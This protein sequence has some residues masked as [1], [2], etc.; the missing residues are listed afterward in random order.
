MKKIIFFLLIICQSILSF[1]QES[2][3][4]SEETIWQYSKDE[5]IDGLTISDLIQEEEFS[6]AIYVPAQAYVGNEIKTVRL[7]FN[8]SAK[9]VKIKIWE[10]LTKDPIYEEEIGDINIT[11]SKWQ[12]FTLKTPFEITEEKPLYIG[13]SL[14]IEP[15]KKPIGIHKDISPRPYSFFFR[16]K[17]YEWSDLSS[18]FAPVCIQAYIYGKL[19]QK[20][21]V[22]VGGETS[23]VS[24]PGQSATVNLNLI[25]CGTSAANV[26]DIEYTINGKTNKL[27]SQNVIARS[28]DQIIFPLE[29]QIPEELGYYKLTVKVSKVDGRN[30][31]FTGKDHEISVAVLEN[32]TKRVVVCEELTG[33]GCAYCPKGIEGLRIMYEKYPDTFLGIAVHEFNGG[34]KMAVADGS[35][36]EINTKMTNAPTCM[37][38][39][40][41]DLIGDPYSKIEEMYLQEAG[42]YPNMKVDMYVKPTDD[43]KK[44]EITTDLT[45]INSNMDCNYKIAFVVIEDKVDKDKDGNKLVQY[46]AG[47]SGTPGAMHGWGDRDIWVEWSFDDVARGIYN[48]DGISN[49]VPEKV[50]A[51]Q[52][53]RYTYTLNVPYV[54]N[55]ENIRIAALIINADTKLIENAGIIKYSDFGQEP[56]VVGINSTKRDNDIKVKKTE[57]G[58]EL[59]TQSENESDIYVYTVSGIMKYNLK[60]NSNNIGI[61]I[62]DPGV[63]IIRII[64]GNHTT[65]IKVIK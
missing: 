1:S 24:K 17:D 7:G 46:N 19:T 57:N 25:N 59:M 12:E 65:D 29:V 51:N 48:Y 50:T 37:I 27:T 23:I 34:D 18:Q 40:N 36:D 54:L 49:S 13:Y 26:V 45:F 55:I 61:P 28:L 21:S 3:N 2:D 8:D 62:T 56:P 52:T 5:E 43:N 32:P 16:Q 41:D 15:D 58:F 30:N 35:Y 14:N 60:S 53:Y 22:D 42:K 44:M 33:T 11:S 63:Y 20:K 31:E 39:R 6:C 9:N 64:Q 47:F 10:K 4:D 38:D